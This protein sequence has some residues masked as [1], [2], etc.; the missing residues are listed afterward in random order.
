[1]ATNLPS[2]QNG[3]P[4]PIDN[5][6]PPKALRIRQQPILTTTQA[7]TTMK[8]ADPSALELALDE[9]RKAMP[10]KIPI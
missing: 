1:M 9:I 6:P 8:K 4:H 5:E 3:V 10:I 2:Y 7:Y